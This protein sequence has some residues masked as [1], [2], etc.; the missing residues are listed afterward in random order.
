M[1]RNKV[2]TYKGVN[3]EQR[4]MTADDGLLAECCNLTPNER[5]ELCPTA[6]LTSL[7]TLSNNSQRL[8]F[9]H[10]AMAYKNFLFTDVTPSTL[11]VHVFTNSAGAFVEN[12][13]AAFVVS[14]W[15]DAWKNINKICAVGNTLVFITTKGIFYSLYKNGTYLPLGQLPEL[16]VINWGA[17]GEQ[18]HYSKTE[19]DI[20]EGKWN[21]IKT[22]LCPTPDDEG[23]EID[24]DHTETI[25]FLSNLVN[26]GITPLENIFRT[27]AKFVYPFF[28]RYAYRGYDN[29][30]LKVSA[31]CLITPST[32]KNF[33]TKLYCV[34]KEN[35]AQAIY[36]YHICY[37]VYYNVIDMLNFSLHYSSNDYIDEPLRDWKDIITSVDVFITPPIFTRN[38]DKNIVKNYPKSAEGANYLTDG[39]SKYFG[40]FNTQKTTDDTHKYIQRQIKVSLSTPEDAP[41]GT[42]YPNN[43]FLDIN[44]YSK[45]RIDESIKAAST[46]YKVKSFSV[47]DIIKYA[48]IDYT[49]SPRVD[50]N[51]DVDTLA[52]LEQQEKLIDDYMAH[53]RLNATNG[54]VY[55]ARLNLTGLKQILYNGF[56]PETMGMHVDNTLPS[57]ST[58][59]WLAYTYI[60]NN[61]SDIIV[62]SDETTAFLGTITPNFFYYPDIAAYKVILKCTYDS[63]SHWYELPLKQHPYLNGA[64]W[65]D[66][67]STLTKI[68][69]ATPPSATDK[70]RVVLNK[71]Y[72]SEVNNPFMFPIGG[73]NTVGVGELLGVASVTSAISEGQFGAFP[74]YVFSTEGV[75]AMHVGSD[76]LFSAIT[77]VSREV[78]N[79]V[80]SITPIDGG[81]LFSTAKG[82]MLIVGGK[83]SCIS[84]N[85]DG[86][87]LDYTA[88]PSRDGSFSTTE[89]NTAYHGNTQFKTWLSTADAFVYDYARRRIIITRLGALNGAIAWIYDLSSGLWTTASESALGYVMPI[90]ASVN[91]YPLSYLQTTL[92]DSTC[93]ILSTDYN[94]T[95][96]SSAQSVGAVFTRPM[97]FDA[98]GYK[99]I[100]RIIHKTTLN[101]S[102]SFVKMQLWGSND[103]VKWYYISSLYGQ[104]FKY[105]VFGLRSQML[106]K[107]V[108]S[109]SVVTYQDVLE[110][111]TR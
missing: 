60:H 74:L 73:I 88:L 107:D 83:I 105:Y 29:S 42:V 109:Y 90:Y 44:Y 103:C 24:K 27:E 93:V 32:Y 2:I 110:D 70:T 4:D 12:V 49:T 11:T 67:F 81:V 36:S 6:P 71:V 79:N 9:V 50:L 10:S 30:I 34:K 59:K 61:T 13:D 31:P 108:L 14:E 3:V 111:K 39:T 82:L 100:R 45:D 92:T 98:Q 56:A 54:M 1:S 101:N 104:P 40:T 66:E 94:D 20:G 21:V 64:Y 43:C 38:Q 96:T 26:S 19:E 87:T 75:Y 84:S 37:D 57:Q 25:P 35:V 76:G 46:Y 95:Y 72:T 16:P 91:D 85:L 8:L 63:N 47:D 51:L 52:T 15:I 17:V 106:Q 41:D 97:K 22:H 48:D 62:C 78:C 7:G 89:L 55:N 80:K 86:V 28:I 68:T 5:G 102:N 99:T 58:I 65:F 18:K 53:H 33:L 23:T 69:M 77:P